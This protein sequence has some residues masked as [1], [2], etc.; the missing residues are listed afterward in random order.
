M[1][2]KAIADHL[3][4]DED[5]IMDWRV[6]GDTVN[7]VVNNDIAGCPKVYIPLSDFD[8]IV[9]NIVEAPDSI[10]I[11]YE[12]PTKDF[13]QMNVKELKR[14]AEQASIIGFSSMRK[15][16]LIEALEQWQQ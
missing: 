5:R 15:A 16:E 11:T 13:A 7:V 3:N 4:I 8:D 14:E 6:D 12:I 10:P 2:A 1:N 9:Y